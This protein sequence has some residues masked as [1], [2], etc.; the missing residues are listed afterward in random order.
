MAE[1]QVEFDHEWGERA[2]DGGYGRTHALVVG[3]DGELL[4]AHM[5]SPGGS[6]DRAAPAAITVLDANGARVDE[7]AHSFAWGIHGM[8]ASRLPDG[9]PGLWLCDKDRGLVALCDRSGSVVRSLAA[10]QHAAYPETAP[11]TDRARRR[12]D[13]TCYVVDGYGASLLHVYSA[14]GQYV[15]SING[16]GE[17]RG[18]FQC[19]HGCWIDARSGTAELVVADRIPRAAWYALTS[20]PAG[21]HLSLF[22]LPRRLTFSVHRSYV[23]QTPTDRGSVWQRQRMGRQPAL[24]WPYWR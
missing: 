20:A 12:P 16:S 17:D 4:V 2:N 6:R 11:P 15:Q 24:H 3:A 23:G 14:D 9:Q 19:P 5:Q 10:P 22:T 7:Y 18:G 13:G 21:T 8:T 1:L